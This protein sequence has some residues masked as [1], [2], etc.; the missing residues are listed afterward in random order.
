MTS[1]QAVPRNG[2]DAPNSSSFQEYIAQPSGRTITLDLFLK[3]L[4]TYRARKV[5]FN[6]LY[7]KKKAVY[8]H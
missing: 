2:V 7:L 5:I 4:I 1:A 8:R 3:R 6:Y